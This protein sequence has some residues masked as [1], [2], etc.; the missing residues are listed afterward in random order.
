MILPDAPRDIALTLWQQAAELISDQ[1]NPYRFSGPEQHPDSQN[2]GAPA[3]EGC[4][5]GHKNQFDS[6][7]PTLLLAGLGVPVKESPCHGQNIQ[8]G[9]KAWHYGV[10]SLGFL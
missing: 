7:S 9:V 4:N 5:H 1:R 10:S 8:A 2:I 3:D 6:H